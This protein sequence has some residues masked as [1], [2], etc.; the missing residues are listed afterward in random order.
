LLIHRRM[1]RVEHGRS[2]LSCQRASTIGCK[3]KARWC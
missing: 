3:A 1:R 2:G